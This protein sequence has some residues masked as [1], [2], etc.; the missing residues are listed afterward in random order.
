[1]CSKKEVSFY[2]GIDFD[3][4]TKTEFMK[5]TDIDEFILGQK[6]QATKYKDN[7]FLFYIYFILTVGPGGNNLATRFYYYYDYNYFLV[8]SIRLKDFAFQ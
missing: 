5:D 8:I 3:C 1:M 4:E 6:A 2:F 7:R